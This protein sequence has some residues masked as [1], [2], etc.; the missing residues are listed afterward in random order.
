[1]ARI[2]HRRL[3]PRSALPSTAPRGPGAQLDSISWVG[4][5]FG[6][7]ALATFAYAL[8]PVL[9]LGDSRLWDWGQ[10][11]ELA[12]GGLRD[13]AIVGLPFALELGVPGARRL[14]PW[15]LR[16]TVLLALDQLARPAIVAAEDMAFTTIFS[17]PSEG[18]PMA[19]W[20]AF[21]LVGLVASLLGIGGVWA[22]AVGLAD[23]GAWLGR[24]KTT[25]LLAAGTAVSLMFIPLTGLVGEATVPSIALALAG[26]LLGMVETTLWFLAGPRLIAGFALQLRPRRAWGLAAI[27]GCATLAVR[28][29]TPVLVLTAFSPPISVAIRILAEGGWIALSLAFALGLGRGRERR[30]PRPVRMRLF[31]RNPTG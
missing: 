16:A 29:L 15:L 25:A 26:F 11:A 8:R 18:D 30:R 6:L 9:S 13:A 24:G 5:L 31:V 28:L 7:A 10:V 23:A 1:M 27:A 20:Q 4:W 2:V 17:D 14:T 22:L 3:A 21:T 19:L 12:L